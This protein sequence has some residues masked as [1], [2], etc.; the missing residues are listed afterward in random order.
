MDGSF[1]KEI[2]KSKTDIVSLFSRKVNEIA[3]YTMY[4]NG[5]TFFPGDML[6]SYYLCKEI[7]GAFYIVASNVTVATALVGCDTECLRSAIRHSE[8]AV[9]RGFYYFK[10]TGNRAVMKELTFEEMQKIV[11]E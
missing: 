5:R 1:N 4:L 11:E 9:I 6:W 7:K 10:R 2:A 8:N 3:F